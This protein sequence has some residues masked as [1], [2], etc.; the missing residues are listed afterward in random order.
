MIAHIAGEVTD[1]NLTHVVVNVGGVGYEISVSERDLEQISSGKEVFLYTYFA[2]R[3]NAQELYGF[4]AADAKSL[5]QQ[6]LSVSGVGPKVA[7]SIMGLGEANQVRSE[8]ANSNVAFIQSANGVG[9][10]GAEKVIVELKDKV[11]P[12]GF[13][14]S[15][16]VAAMNRQDDAAAALV[17]L[18]YSA[19]QA[20]QALAAVDSSLSVEDR[21]KRALGEL[22]Q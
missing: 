20:A 13:T 15:G 10:R 19:S 22:N 11:G 6:L 3:E 12:A 2:V 4:L 1:K 17:A 21:I 7:M 8:I 14:A 18:G 16:G 9:K 5:F